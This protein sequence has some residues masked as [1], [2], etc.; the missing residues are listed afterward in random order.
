MSESSFLISYDRFNAN[1]R[2]KASPGRCCVP[3]LFINSNHGPDLLWPYQS[4][5]IKVYK[6][7]LDITDNKRSPPV[8]GHSVAGLC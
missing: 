8:A 6:S 5:R 4:I 3:K 7:K 2:A 1:G